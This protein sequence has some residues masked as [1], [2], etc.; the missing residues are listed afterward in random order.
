MERVL[1]LMWKLLVTDS[2]IV[3][4]LFPE[5]SGSYFCGG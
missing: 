4:T 5:H 1:S 3:A 2:A